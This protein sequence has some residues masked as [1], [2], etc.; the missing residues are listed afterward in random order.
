M[1]AIEIEFPTENRPDPAEGNECPE[2]T[3]QETVVDID[4]ILAVNSIEPPSRA[5]DDYF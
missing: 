4:D 2:R 5:F 1:G 3:A